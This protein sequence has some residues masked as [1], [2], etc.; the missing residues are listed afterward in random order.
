MYSSTFSKGDSTELSNNSESHFLMR[1][2]AVFG[3]TV[4]MILEVMTATKDFDNN[5]NH[6]RKL[7]DNNGNN[8]DVD[9]DVNDGD[10][11][12]DNDVND[13]DG[14][15]GD[16]DGDDGDND[17]GDDDN[18][19]D[20]NDGD[21]D[22]DDSDDDNTY[23]HGDSDIRM[24]IVVGDHSIMINTSAYSLTCS[25]VTSRGPDASRSSTAD[26]AP[27]TNIT[28]SPARKYKY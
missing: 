4:M 5:D 8:N 14:R 1:Q 16:G 12:D 15:H 9:D 17:G 3:V 28:Y 21:G 24:V 2:G 7:N 19:D 6:D 27:F 18:D 26:S 25:S 13:R 22:S 11:G 23:D 20:D 10:D